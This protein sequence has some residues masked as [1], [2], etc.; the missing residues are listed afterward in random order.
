MQNYEKIQQLKRDIDNATGDVVAQK[1]RRLELLLAEE[2]AAAL[3]AIA[4]QLQTIAKR[5]PQQ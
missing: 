4:S 3:G 2:I 5:M 1:Q